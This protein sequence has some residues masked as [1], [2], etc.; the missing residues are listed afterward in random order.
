MYTFVSAVISQNPLGDFWAVV[1]VMATSSAAQFS[2]MAHLTTLLKDKAFRAHAASKISELK[3]LDQLKWLVADVGSLGVFALSLILIRP[4]LPCASGSLQPS[5]CV[6]L[7]F[8]SLVAI[9]INLILLAMVS[10]FVGGYDFKRLRRQV[11]QSQDLTRVTVYLQCGRKMVGSILDLRAVY[12]AEGFALVREDG[13]IEC[14]ESSQVATLYAQSGQK[15]DRALNPALF[16][17]GPKSLVVHFPHK[18]VFRDSFFYDKS[19]FRVFSIKKANTTSDFA[20]VRKSWVA[21]IPEYS[22]R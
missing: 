4:M 15:S 7:A 12:Y 21:E 3:E 13:S 8:I 2:L 18:E 1:A 6:V 14:V 9:L 22:Y 5:W 16:T 17:E 10:L 11:A 19:E 20:I